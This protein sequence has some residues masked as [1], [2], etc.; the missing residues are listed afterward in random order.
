MDRKQ[1]DYVGYIEYTEEGKRAAEI[2]YKSNEAGA[3]AGYSKSEIAK[4]AAFIIIILEEGIRAKPKPIQPQEMNFDRIKDM[5]DIRPE[6]AERVE[7]IM[8]II[9]ENLKEAISC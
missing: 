1:K 8:I 4:A 3:L 6:E 2:L 9:I 5:I 7:D